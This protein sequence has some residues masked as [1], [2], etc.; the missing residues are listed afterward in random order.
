[1]KRAKEG[2]GRQV[3]RTEKERG[4]GA[5]GREG[6]DWWKE[7]WLFIRV[8]VCFDSIKANAERLARG[9]SGIVDFPPLAETMR[10]AAETEARFSPYLNP[11]AELPR[12][13]E[14]LEELANSSDTKERKERAKRLIADCRVSSALAYAQIDT[15]LEWEFEHEEGE[16]KAD[17]L[18]TKLKKERGD[19]KSNRK[20]KRKMKVELAVALPLLALRCVYDEGKTDK[21]GAEAMGVSLSTFKSLLQ[22]GREMKNRLKEMKAG[23]I[24]KP[25][26]RG[27]RKLLGGQQTRLANEEGKKHREEKEQ[28]EIA[29][30]EEGR[31]YRPWQDKFYD[32]LDGEGEG[33][34]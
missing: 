21:E 32:N 10:E 22:K 33:E 17:A 15:I 26:S 9:E 4:R 19:K 27:R 6:W 11:L 28:W 20:R 24:D 34:E 5:G 2:E 23:N 29:E 1:M 7:T 13:A 8:A 16:E 30:R 25:R 14:A 31:R 3:K 18:R 12:A